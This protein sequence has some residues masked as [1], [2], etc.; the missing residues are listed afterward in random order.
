MSSPVKIAGSGQG[1]QPDSSVFVAYTREPTWRSPNSSPADDDRGL[2]LLALLPR[3]EQLEPGHAGHA[4]V[5]RAHL[6][7]RDRDHAHVEELDVRQRS[8]VDLLQHLERSGPLHLVAVELPV[9]GIDG[10]ALVALRGRVVVSRLA[11]VLDPVVC[12]RAPDET[13]QLVVEVEENGIADDMAVVVAGDELLGLVDGKIVKAVDGKVRE[14]SERVGSLDVEIRHV[15]R[16]VEETR[17]LAPGALLV[18]PVRE[19]ARHARIDIRADLRVAREVDRAP[20][21]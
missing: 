1:I 16:L 10:G 20:G 11:V 6:V 3:A 17:C 2:D 9:A 4:V 7:A 5:Q 13:E 18:A 15:V 12:R 19:F 21:L 8:A 14:Q